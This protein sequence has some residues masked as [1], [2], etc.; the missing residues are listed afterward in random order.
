MYDNNKNNNN[1]QCV[2]EVM[3]VPI[4]TWKKVKIFKINNT[5]DIH[6]NIINI[7]S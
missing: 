7:V 5:R 6:L 4:L 2:F 3:K 1:N